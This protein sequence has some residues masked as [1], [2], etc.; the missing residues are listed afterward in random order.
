MLS[1]PLSSAGYKQHVDRA[2]FFGVATNPAFSYN[3]DG[4]LAQI[5]YNSNGAT[6]IMTYTDGYL[7]RID[8]TL[9][10]A[11]TRKTFNY[12]AEGFLTSIVEVEI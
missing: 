8:S 7:T 9:R 10:G 12:D 11:T 2:I 1:Q 5:T 6:K 4:T 3:V